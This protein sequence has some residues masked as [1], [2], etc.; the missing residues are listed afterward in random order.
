MHTETQLTTTRLKLRPPRRGDEQDLFAI[1]SDPVVMRYF[2]EPA[3]TDPERAT[4]QID[5][6]AGRFERAESFRFA[7]VLADTGRVIGNCTVY[8]L[9]RQNRRG[10]IGYALARDYWGHGYM[11]EALQALLAF[12]F[13]ECDLHRLEADIDPRNTA[14]ASALTR[15][16][17]TQEGLLRERWIVAGEVSDSALYGLLRSEWEAARPSAST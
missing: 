2:S 16:G 3:W 17:F 15:L 7:I 1:H 11:Q 10:E 6:D 8:A 13:G 5:D 12:A 9:H 14:S 4:R